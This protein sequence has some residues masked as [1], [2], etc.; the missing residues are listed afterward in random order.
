MVSEERIVGGFE[1]IEISLQLLVLVPGATILEPDGYL[2]RL[3]P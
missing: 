3:E 1:E 2:S